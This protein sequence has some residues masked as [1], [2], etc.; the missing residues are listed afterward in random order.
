MNR[1]TLLAHIATI[2]AMIIFGGAI[3]A[4]RVAGRTIPPFSLAVLRFG[5]AGGVLL[6]ALFLLARQQLVVRRSDWPLFLGMGI[7]FAAFAFCFNIGFRFTEASRGGLMLAT[8]P[9]WSALFSRLAG[10]ERLTARQLVGLFLT[11]GGIFLVVAER[12][13]QWQVGGRALIGDL[14]LLTGVIVGS[15]NSMVGKIAYRRYTALPVTTYTMLLASAL[16]L[17]AALPEGLPAVV[18]G[19]DGAR[20]A[21]VL[22]LGLPAGALAYY[23]V[24]AALRHLTLTQA[25]VYININPLTATVLGAILLGERLTVPFLVGFA[26]VLVG[27]LLVNLPKT[28]RLWPRRAADLAPA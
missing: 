7:S 9:F 5:L 21:L 13:L 3:V 4:T 1:Q 25:S 2:V 20:L 16:L 23:M 6:V 24:F 26:I 28:L 11:L 27:V 17:L 12:G 10:W 15:L 8:L 19:F 14:L 18:S 22:Y